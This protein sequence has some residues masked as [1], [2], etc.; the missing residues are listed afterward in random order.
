MLILMNNEFIHICL[1][2]QILQ[3]QYILIMLEKAAGS[4]FTI[5]R[6]HIGKYWRGPVETSKQTRRR[7]N[8]ALT[9][10]GGEGS[11]GKN[12]NLT[13]TKASCS[14]TLPAKVEDC[15]EKWSCKPDSTNLWV[16]REFGKAAGALW[17][18]LISWHSLWWSWSWGL[19]SFIS[20]QQI[21]CLDE[22]AF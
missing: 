10:R 21:L 5:W 11:P 22:P 15:K 20:M 4:W 1:I 13:R 14:S 8:P 6:A 19:L 2:I 7:R 3:Q 12:E 18:L 17:T 9:G 16:K